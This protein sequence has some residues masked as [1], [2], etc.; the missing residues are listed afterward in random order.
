MTVRAIR[1]AIVVVE[2]TPACVLDATQRLV[3]A[4]LERN[5][6]V[7]EDLI[8]MLFTVTDDIT[9]VFPAEAARRMGLGSVPLMCAREIPVAGS[10]PLVVRVLMHLHTQRSLTEVEPVYLDGAE[11]LRDDLG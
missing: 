4:M 2:D 10:M 9:S 7:G 6:A 3:E 11:S 5:G 1:G 8:S